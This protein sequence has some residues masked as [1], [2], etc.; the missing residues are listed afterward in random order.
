MRIGISVLTHAGQSIWE[1]GLG[2]HV[3]FLAHL[4]RSLPFVGEVLLF[5][6]GDQSRL[7][8]DLEEEGGAGFRLIAPRDATDLIDVA[9]EMAGGLDASWLDHL[10]AKGKKVVYHCCGQPYA[11]L[12]EPSIFGTA[13]YFSRIERCDEI[14]T[15]PRDRCFHRMFESLYRC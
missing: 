15:L 10:R 9:I 3:F 1:N 12:V 14:W 5:N 13:G 2:Q 6:C 4:L 7:P 11:A 8:D